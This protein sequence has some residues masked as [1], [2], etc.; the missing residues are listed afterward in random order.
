MD[1]MDIPV[2]LRIEEMAEGFDLQGLTIQTPVLLFYQTHGCVVSQFARVDLF[3]RAHGR[4]TAGCEE[5]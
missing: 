3:T 5:P 4:V 1:R 2:E